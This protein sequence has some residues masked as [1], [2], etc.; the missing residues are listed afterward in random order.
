MK[1]LK[2]A[3]DVPMTRRDPQSG[4]TLHGRRFD[5]P[6]AWLEQIHNPETQ[7]WIAAQEAVTRAVLDSVSGRDWLREADRFSTGVAA[8][9][10]TDAHVPGSR[11]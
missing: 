9:S 4:Y 11:R 6:Y 3:L 8:T 10:H 2:G 1:K 7:A 5:D